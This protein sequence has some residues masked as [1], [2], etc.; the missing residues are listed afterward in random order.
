MAGFYPDAPSR[1][2]A[3]DV[4]GTTGMWMRQD[5]TGGSS[6]FTV[7]NLA[8]L[9]SE[10]EQLSLDMG[11]NQPGKYAWLQFPQKRDVDGTFLSIHTSGVPG[12][13][14]TSVDTTNGI[15]GTWVEK[16]ANYPDI[17]TTAVLWRED[18]ELYTAAGIYGT[19]IAVGSTGATY[20]RWAT[21]HTYGTIT[22]GETPDRLLFLDTT[23]S[24]NEFTAPLDYGEIARG[25]TQDRTIKL[26][27]NSAS[28]QINTIQITA[29]DS[30]L[31]AGTLYE[32]SDDDITYS[33]TLALGNLT[34]GSEILVY[35]RQTLDDAE[36]LGIMAGRFKASHA[37]MT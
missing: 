27:N 20:Q 8:N 36:T 17:Y 14:A 21:W 26:K 35:V 4:D 37:S 1:R 2:M 29:E 30:Y 25:T 18:I 11:Y 12:Q 31:D 15:D 7:A 3:T 16:V 22:A 23:D 28:L 6:A 9:N 24:D 5:L 32:F 13:L 19:R 33:A 10:V 34:F